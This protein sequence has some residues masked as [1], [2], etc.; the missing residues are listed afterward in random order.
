MYI[1]PVS[2]IIHRFGPLLHSY[3]DDTQL[4]VTAKKQDRFVDTLFDIEQCV[5]EIK[6][7]MN[8]NMLKLNVISRLDYCKKT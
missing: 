4:Y 1:K 7:W 3:A 6:V 5:S 8:Y 2:D